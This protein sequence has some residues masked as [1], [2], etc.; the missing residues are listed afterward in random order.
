MTLDWLLWYYARALEL[1]FPVLRTLLTHGLPI[2]RVNIDDR[3]ELLVFGIRHCPCGPAVEHAGGTKQW[4]RNGLLHR[5]DGPAIE[6]AGNKQ[7]WRNGQM[8]RDDGP[9]VDY[10]YYKAW[11]H[12]GLLH[13]DDGPAVE[14]SNGNHEYWRNGIQYWPSN[15][16]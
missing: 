13:R 14:R 6:W 2:T 8:H 4:Y 16:K 12:N 7:W 3:I 10:D 11:Y 5:D 9:A 1:P 15:Q